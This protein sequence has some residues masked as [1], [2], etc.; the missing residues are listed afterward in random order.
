MP[1]LDDVM[2][3]L[4]SDSAAGGLGQ[5]GGESG[6]RTSAVLFNMKYGGHCVLLRHRET[7]GDHPLWPF[8][9]LQLPCERLEQVHIVYIFQCGII[10]QLLASGLGICKPMTGLRHDC[11]MPRSPKGVRRDYH[12]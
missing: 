2:L 3:T 12:S 4:I 11:I 1:T 10:F 6:L 5:G 7:Y 8:L 9:C